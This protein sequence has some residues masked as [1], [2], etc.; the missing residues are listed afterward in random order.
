MRL[1]GTCV[2]ALALLTG[3]GTTVRRMQPVP[4]PAVMDRPSPTARC[5]DGTYAY[6]QWET[7]DTCSQHGGVKVWWGR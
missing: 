5:G 7:P 4:S 2:V 1:L 6:D 3:C